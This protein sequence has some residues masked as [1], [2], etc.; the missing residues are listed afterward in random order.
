[1]ALLRVLAVAAAAAVSLALSASADM[2]CKYGVPFGVGRTISKQR[3]YYADTGYTEFKYYLLL[4]SAAKKSLN[5]RVELSPGFTVADVVE[6]SVTGPLGKLMINPYVTKPQG[7]RGGNPYFIWRFAQP[8][9]TWNYMYSVVFSGNVGSVTGTVMVKGENPYSMEFCSPGLFTVRPSPPPPPAPI[10]TQEVIASFSIT[11]EYGILVPFDELTQRGFIEYVSKYITVEGVKIYIHENS[12]DYGRRRLQGLRAVKRPPPLFQNPPPVDYYEMETVYF[13]AAFGAPV[14]K[15]SEVE[16]EVLA[17]PNPDSYLDY[18]GNEISTGYEASSVEITS[19]ASPPPP[20]P[21]P[22]KSP[23]PSPP[24]PPSP[25]PPPFPP[26][27]QGHCPKGFVESPLTGRCYA[28]LPGPGDPGSALISCGTLDKA[29]VLAK[30]TNYGEQVFV[31]GLCPTSSCLI[32]VQWKKIVEQGTFNG[33]YSTI[34]GD[35]NA[36]TSNALGDYLNGLRGAYK[37]SFGNAV[38]NKPPDY[39]GYDYASAAPPVE[40]EVGNGV[41]DL[42]WFQCANLDTKSLQIKL[43]KCL[44]TSSYICST[45][46]RVYVTTCDE[47][48]GGLTGQPMIDCRNQCKLDGIERRRLLGLEDV[49]EAENPKHHDVPYSR[50]RL[51]NKG[52]VDVHIEKPALC[53][54]GFAASPSGRCFAYLDRELHADQAIA[55]CAA[56]HPGGQVAS[57]SSAAEMEMLHRL[58]VAGTCWLGMYKEEVHAHGFKGACVAYDEYNDC[59]SGFAW[60]KSRK[61][62][63]SNWAP[64]FPTS[65]GGACVRMEQGRGWVN[66]PCADL[67]AV[68]CEVHTAAVSA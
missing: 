27:I 25:R 53:P 24:P 55:Q 49:D 33:N 15:L 34:N 51:P 7:E 59:V 22:P 3:W 38:G 9:S 36:P 26:T 52:P 54:E 68:I 37:V 47:V 28:F 13:T 46:T 64:G 23:P 4:H 39:Q 35:F 61:V 50:K 10:Y 18:Q 57:V 32:N 42:N 16:A 30:V 1:M 45:P 5:F 21:K 41:F 63:F 31:M 6:S 11:A 66:A 29:S 17:I 14:S 65:S 60:S 20:P 19:A 56:L 44:P 62:T 8:V 67:A 48:C 40:Q 2:V 58:C 12:F 43:A